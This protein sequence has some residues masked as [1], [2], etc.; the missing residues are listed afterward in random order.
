MPLRGVP[1][2]RRRHQTG[3]RPAEDGLMRP[4]D[5]AEGQSLAHAASLARGTGQGETDAPTQFLAG[6]TNLIDLMKLDVLTPRRLVSLGALTDANERIEL[7]GEELLLGGFARMAAAARHPLVLAHCPA[8]AQSLALAASAQLRN[9]ATLGGNV[10]QKTRCTY[11]RD[12]SWTACNKRSPGSGCA[13]LAGFNRNHAVLGVDATCIAQY[14]G[15]FAVVL[16]AL[17]AQVDVTGPRGARRMPFAALHTPVSGRPHIETTLGEGEIITQFRVPVNAAT[18]RSVYVKVRDRA[19]YE[20]AIASAA[21]ALELDG[22]MVRTVRIGLGGMAYTPWRS[23]EA[24]Q[25]LTGQP[26][27][28]AAMTAAATAALAGATTHGFNDYKPEL[29]RR[30][31]VRAL[32][33]AQALPPRAAA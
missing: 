1:E 19:S 17:D 28:A 18:R 14:P 15:D 5:F 3:A 25:A 33:E 6:G 13:A 21:V 7:R 20:F 29:A 8:V 27:T 9:M 22:A 12:T 16:A 31:L 10:L 26:L 32:L 30:T 24:E 11:Y 2:D 4:F 23:R